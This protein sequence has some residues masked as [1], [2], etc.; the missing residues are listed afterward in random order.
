MATTRLL[1]AIEMDRPCI[2]VSPPGFGQAAILQHIAQ[3]LGWKFIHEQFND[4][5]LCDAG[6]LRN[7]LSPPVEQQRALLMIEHVYCKQSVKI[8]ES[9]PCSYADSV[10]MTRLDTTL[11]ILCSP[12][13]PQ[14]FTQSRDN[15]LQASPPEWLIIYAH[16]LHMAIPTSTQQFLNTA[17]PH[18]HQSLLGAVRLAECWPPMGSLLFAK[19]RGLGAQQKL[20]DLSHQNPDASDLQISAHALKSTCS[21]LLNNFQDMMNCYAND[22]LTHAEQ[23]LAAHLSLFP[24]NIHP[25]LEHLDD[26]PDLDQ[27]I[28]R[29]CF[30][31]VLVY[32]EEHSTKGR[33]RLLSF[34]S[35]AWRFFSQGHLRR[36]CSAMHIDEFVNKV[37]Q[38]LVDQTLE[39][40]SHKQILAIEFNLSARYYENAIELIVAQT[41][42]PTAVQLTQDQFDQAVAWLRFVPQRL[43]NQSPDAKLLQSY[44]R[45][46]ADNKIAVDPNDTR[47]LAHVHRAESMTD[48]LLPV[49]LSPRIEPHQQQGAP[50]SSTVSLQS[51]TNANSSGYSSQ[52]SLL[53]DIQQHV[54]TQEI[55]S[56]QQLALQM[57]DQALNRQRPELFLNGLIYFWFTQTVTNGAEHFRQY[58][59]QILNDQRLSTQLN[60]FRYWLNQL[61]SFLDEAKIKPKS[62]DEDSTLQVIHPPQIGHL[63]SL[64]QNLLGFMTSYLSAYI[65][66]L[67]ACRTTAM[68]RLQESTYFAMNLP[69]SYSQ[70]L[71]PIWLIEILAFIQHNRLREALTYIQNLLQNLDQGSQRIQTPY[72]NS[73]RALHGHFHG[74]SDVGNT[75]PTTITSP[76]SE[77]LEQQLIIFSMLWQ[78]QYKK[79]KRAL[80]KFLKTYQDEH[81]YFSWVLFGPSS[82]YLMSLLQ[83]ADDCKPRELQ[84]CADIQVNL[85]ERFSQAFE[86]DLAF[87]NLSKREVE[88]TGLVVLGHSNEEIANLLCRSLGTIKLHVHSVYKKLGVA[89]RVN[90]IKKCQSSGFF[91]FGL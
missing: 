10:S 65:A 30:K 67:R 66:L 84:R 91:S 20:S 46:M 52:A 21:E 81:S 33:L 13:A 60:E 77:A 49:N 36:T 4:Q 47:K 34:A 18:L 39:H 12:L 56:A 37:N 54:E 24:P 31:N 17:P 8:L 87:L 27:L 57:I 61:F 75:S 53:L 68:E 9:A 16:E 25:Y 23:S 40:F 32:R 71:M 38:S 26:L 35:L 15:D 78:H 2:I 86:F 43:I 83:C 41:N 59:P 82:W 6:Y 11:P 50:S 69:D 70:S 48:P 58:L 42:R 51:L 85:A 3:Q 79:A 90:A 7:A 14:L 1:K 88:I 74:N 73:F 72:I 89:N 45:L 44:Q 19:L 63:A 62:K 28:Q 80:S 29:L 22:I 55:M 5:Q 76:H 64:G